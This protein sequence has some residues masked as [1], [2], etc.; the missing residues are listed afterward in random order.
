MSLL[1]VGEAIKTKILQ[2]CAT[3]LVPPS[4]GFLF[5][6]CSQEKPPVAAEPRQE[7]VVSAEVT[8]IPAVAAAPAAAQTGVTAS[9]VWFDD[10]LSLV[11]NDQP[12]V[13]TVSK[14]GVQSPA[15]AATTQFADTRPE[16][17]ATSAGGEF[18]WDELISAEA[19]DAEVKE[20]R[21]FLNQ[22]LRTVGSF[23]S[24]MFEFPPRTATLATLA[25][26]AQRHS[27]ELRWK[28]FAAY[29]RDQAATMHAETLQRGP[30]F[31]GAL[32]AA[33]ENINDAFAGSPPDDG[34]SG[35][36]DFSEIVEVGLLMKRIDIAFNKLKTDGGNE[37]GFESESETLAREAAVLATLM[38]VACAEDLGYGDDE[39]FVSYA[40]SV[41]TAVKEINSAIETNNFAAFDAAVGTITNACAQCHTVF[42][43]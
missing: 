7:T 39:E 4:I 16:A 31:Q 8:S 1:N 10:P 6:G 11:A 38:K 21:N 26:V 32:L 12:V 42:N 23:N 20:I 41:L 36:V 29:I 9:R 22:R 2:P 27:G 37:S 43:D 30:K 3:L 24:S 18:A 14:V 25:A 17:V 15:A 19:I 35:P 33:F 5:I 34:N 40:D 28:R 13:A